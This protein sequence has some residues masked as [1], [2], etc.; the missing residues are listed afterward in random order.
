MMADIKR[1]YGRIYEIY[2]VE[3]EKNNPVLGKPSFGFSPTPEQA[4]GGGPVILRELHDNETIFQ[5]DTL[6]E[7]AARMKNYQFNNL[8][9]LSDEKILTNDGRSELH[10]PVSDSNL[11]KLA[12]LLKR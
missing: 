8:T 2:L 9:N 3:G 12:L 10:K 1:A 5:E 6:E 4:G 11:E 7:F